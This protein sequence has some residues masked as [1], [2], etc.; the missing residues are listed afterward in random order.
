[1]SQLTLPPILDHC[2]RFHYRFQ[3]IVLVVERAEC[4]SLYYR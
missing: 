1:M 4:S 2:H 3:C